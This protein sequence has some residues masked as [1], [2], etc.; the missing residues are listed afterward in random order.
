VVVDYAYWARLVEAKSAPC[1][2]ARE[3]FR[4]AFFRQPFVRRIQPGLDNNQASIVAVSSR[5]MKPRTSQEVKPCHAIHIL[6][7]DCF[8]SLLL[9]RELRECTC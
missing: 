6:D 1:R 4:S 9:V 8:G 3:L 2:G 7:S 5:I